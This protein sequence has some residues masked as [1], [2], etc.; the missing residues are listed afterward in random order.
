MCVTHNQYSCVH[1]GDRQDFT[2]HVT[3]MR[4]S[5]DP[6]SSVPLANG[7]N[8]PPPDCISGASGS[9][10]ASDFKWEAPRFREFGLLKAMLVR[11]GWPTAGLLE[12]A[13]AGAA[14]AAARATT[15]AAAFPGVC[16]AAGAASEAATARPRRGG[17]GG[18]AVGLGASSAPSKAAA[19]EARLFRGG[20]SGVGA[21]APVHTLVS[22]DHCSKP[23]NAAAERSCTLS[24]SQQRRHAGRTPAA[25]RDAGEAA[26]ASTPDARLC[27]TRR[28]EPPE[29]IKA[30]MCA[31]RVATGAQ[32]PKG[33]HIQRT[34]TGDIFSG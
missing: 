1:Q 23:S 13:A 3:H 18:G 21:G 6:N 9:Q 20:G 22:H 30:C 32:V 7:P 25:W 5:Y 24:S 28:C 31:R 12:A 33:G 27:L 26:T 34:T 16:A 8:A 15:D 11:K 2:R 19:D 17:G 29:F 4:R 10:I 14:A